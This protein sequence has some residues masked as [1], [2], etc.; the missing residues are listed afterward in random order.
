MTPHNNPSL[1]EKDRSEDVSKIVLYY[2]KNFYEIYWREK[3]NANSTK[4]LKTLIIEE[5][6]FTIDVVF[7]AKQLV[8]A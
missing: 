1:I 4:M 7:E 5:V 6:L 2:N 3:E 8:K